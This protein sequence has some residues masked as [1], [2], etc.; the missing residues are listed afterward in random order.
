MDE[1]LIQSGLFFLFFIGFIILRIIGASGKKKESRDNFDSDDSVA[2]VPRDSVAPVP[3]VSSAMPGDL[4][5]SAKDF[6]S[7]PPIPPVQ[8]T[9][10]HTEDHRHPR[11]NVQPPK[12]IRQA[13]IWGEI[14]KRK[15]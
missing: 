11:R 2:P 6:R 1:D 13:I 15:F 12:D 9:M 4:A 14:L 3:R 8:E 5:G 7:L 10:P